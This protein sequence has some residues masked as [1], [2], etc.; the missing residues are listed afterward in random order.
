M[1]RAAVLLGLLVL[2][3]C[4]R[5][6]DY[7]NVAR[8]QQRA[9]QEVTEILARVRDEKDLAAARAE[10]DERV[11]RY[12]AIVRRA[13]ALPQPP[14]EEAQRLLQDEQPAFQTALRR[15]SEQVVRVRA[16]P[17]ASAFFEQYEGR[18]RIFTSAAVTP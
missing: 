8:E 2:T 5:P 11:E 13:K 17:G 7:V 15:L 4:T 12:E 1:R 10:L 6:Q 18:S 16:L 9:M 3:G 14:S